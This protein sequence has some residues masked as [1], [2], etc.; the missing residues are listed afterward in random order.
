MDDEL[1]C[2][3]CRALS[4]EWREVYGVEGHCPICFELRSDLFVSNLCGHV[5]CSP[6]KMTAME[7]AQ[8]AKADN[9]LRSRHLYHDPEIWWRRS[10]DDDDE[11]NEDVQD[12][13]TIDVKLCC[14]HCRISSCKWRE[15]YG[16]KGSCP[17]CFEVRTDL[18]ISKRCGH[19]LCSVCKMT[20]TDVARRAKTESAYLVG[21]NMEL[22]P[23]Q[24]NNAW[25]SYDEEQPYEP[26][27][28][29]LLP[30]T[31]APPYERI[32]G[33]PIPQQSG[34]AW[35]GPDTANSP[36]SSSELQIEVASPSLQSGLAWLGFDTLDTT[37]SLPSA[38]IQRQLD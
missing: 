19:V 6:C 1:S 25:W 3:L 7:V 10:D 17:N 20:A 5:W 34:M 31:T 26:E 37:Q 24:N 4:R 30:P 22:V 9:A 15:V 33:I 38:R 23:E 28:E 29:P 18:F 14:S 21:H 2:S 35:L 27:E 11:D 12:A 32:D 16:V 13:R 8:R 36:S